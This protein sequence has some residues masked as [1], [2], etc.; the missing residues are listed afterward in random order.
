VATTI[1]NATQNEKRIVRYYVWELPVRLVH[2]IIFF[3]IT[4]L[5]VTGYYI[6]SPYLI[7]HGS[8]AYV[9]GTM[10]AIHLS[11]GFIFLAAL[12]LRLY[13][14]FAG[15]Q[16]A[17]WRAFLPLTGTQRKNLKET[18]R[19]YALLR[20]SPPL[21]IGH[22]MLAAPVYAL[23][24]VLCAVEGVTGLVMYNAQLK[25]PILS[26]FIGWIPRVVNIQTLRSIHYFL[27]FAF[28]AF[29]VHHLYSA[30]LT[31]MH[32]RDGLM[33]SI[34]TGNKSVSSHLLEETSLD[35]LEE[36]K[37]VHASHR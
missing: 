8:G 31:A 27:M 34:F 23:I 18:I 11:A 16:F 32:E 37:K 2:W 12:L 1:A 30:I 26:F 5:S 29:L 13:W 17:R 20:Y 14:F 6:H 21:T 19:Y 15:N 22:N 3:T 24:Y 28:W 4:V 25:V 9:M 36:E 10:R 7:A 35:L 33:D